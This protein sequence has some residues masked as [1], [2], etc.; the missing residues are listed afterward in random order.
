MSATIYHDWDWQWTQ[1][2]RA[3]ERAYN[4]VQK[5]LALDDSH[6]TAHVILGRLL[7]E[8]GQFEAA[9]AETDRGIALAPNDTGNY[10]CAASGNVD[11]AADTLNRSGR[12]AQ[13]LEITEKAIRQ[14]PERSDFH[15][16]EVGLAY[17][18]LGRPAEAISALQ[19]FIEAYPVFPDA[20]Y[21][22]TA[23]YVELGMMEKARAEAADI[24]RLSP[25]FS[26]EAGVFKAVDS[27][28]RLLSDL[29]KAGLK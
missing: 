18:E 20:R 2:P 9:A 10:Y 3:L 8:Q 1:D 24:M 13:A 12:P 15:L 16:E 23:S 19:R 25:H 29:R 21:I 14:D 5:A 7:L 17:Y 26:L 27:Q 11:W 22:L 4:L 28:D 6:P